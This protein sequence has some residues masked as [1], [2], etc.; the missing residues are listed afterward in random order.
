M[1]IHRDIWAIKLWL[2]QKRFVKNVLDIYDMSNSKVVSNLGKSHFKLLLDQCLKTCVKVEYR[3]KFS[4]VSVVG[5]L[6]Y[7]LI[8]TRRYLTQVVSQV[9]K[10]MFKRINFHWEAY[11]VFTST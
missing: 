8:C 7:V 9:C 11:N 4:Y 10:F 2:T 5:C 3:S 6:M 1:L